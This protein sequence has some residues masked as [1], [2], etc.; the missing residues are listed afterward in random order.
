MLS[1]CHH[2]AH[3]NGEVKMVFNRDSNSAAKKV[4]FELT[5]LQRGQIVNDKKK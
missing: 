1:R 3:T 4:F 5:N 2:T